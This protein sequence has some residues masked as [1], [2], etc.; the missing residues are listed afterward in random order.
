VE[1]SDGA[2]HII[3]VAIRGVSGKEILNRAPLNI[4]I[5]LPIKVRTASQ[6]LEELC[7]TVS[8]LTHTRVIVGTIPTGMFSKSLG[9]RGAVQITARHALADLLDKAGNGV[10]LSWRLLYDPGMKIYALNIHTVR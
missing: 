7:A 5:T 8:K 4:A 9:K 3:H 1:Q 2:F 10:K 6:E